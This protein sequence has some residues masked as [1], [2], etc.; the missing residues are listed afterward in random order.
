[1]S[2]GHKFDERSDLDTAVDLWISDPDR[3]TND[4]GTDND[5]IELLGGLTENDL[6]FRYLGGHT[7]IS[8]DEGDLLAIVENTIAADITFI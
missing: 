1:M 4:Y 7:R 3:A 6:T 8:D 5:R 2:S